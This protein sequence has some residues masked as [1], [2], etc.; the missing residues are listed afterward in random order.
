[1]PNIILAEFLHGEPKKTAT[2]F[3]NC[4]SGATVMLCVPV[5]NFVTCNVTS[6]SH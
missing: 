3:S 4:V 2:M 1:M 6:S 5:E